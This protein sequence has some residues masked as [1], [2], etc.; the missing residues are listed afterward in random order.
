[1]NTPHYTKI[2][3]RFKFKGYY[4]TGDDL[5]DIGYDFIKEGD[6]Y[7]IA[8][9]KFIMDWMDK[10]D[11][12]NVKTSGSTG[13]PKMIQISKQA[14]VNSA[15]R[16]GDFFNVQIGD[17]ALHCLPTD[18]IAGKMMLVRAMILGLS[19]DL[20]QPTADPMRDLVKYYDFVAMTPMQAHHSLEKLDQI[21]TLIIGGAPVYPELNEKLVSLHN[22]CFETYGMTETIT[23]IAAS[24]LSVPKKPF[25][26]LDGIHLKVDKDCCLVVD[27]PEI[28]DQLI[29]T[30]DLVEMHDDKTFTYLGRRDNVINSGGVKISPEVVEQKLAHHI[31]FP[32]F[33]YGIQD[34]VLGQ[35]L[36]MVVEGDDVHVK[37]AEKHIAAC[38]TLEKFEVPKSLYYVSEI[39]R[40]NGKYMRAKT[41]KTLKIV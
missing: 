13:E 40:N 21:K 32:F 4:F 31:Q 27:A 22:N 38:E 29:H 14:M 35:K 39:L 12:I 34:K 3:N 19:L 30:N 18:F 5:K 41:V 23:H 11:Y 15:I 16:T 20:V 33:L 7:E 2:H 10:E 1:M 24:K 6:P 9:G 36:I 17:T 26:A 28:T 25:R 8:I 37:E